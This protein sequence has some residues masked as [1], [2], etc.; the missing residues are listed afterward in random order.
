MRGA[1]CTICTELLDSSRDVSALKC[2]HLFHADC[3]APWFSQSL[4]CPQCRQKVTKAAV[5]DKLF[6]SRPDGDDSI[7][8]ESDAAVELSRLSTRLEEAQSKLCVRDRELTKLSIEKLMVDECLE[9][10]QSE[11]CVR[12]RELTELDESFRLCVVLTCNFCPSLCFCICV[13]D[14]NFPE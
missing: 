2:G 3:L 5:I 14:V 12:D 1:L 4:T 10:A 7:V 11:L 8:A 13:C 6:F 9:E